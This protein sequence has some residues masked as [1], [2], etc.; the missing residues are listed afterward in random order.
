MF[1]GHFG[2]RTD[3]NFFH[4]AYVTSKTAHTDTIFLFC[5]TLVKGFRVINISCFK[6]PS[7]KLSCFV[8]S[9]LSACFNC[10]NVFV[11]I[12]I[13]FIVL[14]ADDFLILFFYLNA[15]NL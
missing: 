12:A 7:F 5:F 2:R 6:I 11:V 9:K 8:R 15:T 10:K 13:K 3:H 4:R 1:F 14:T